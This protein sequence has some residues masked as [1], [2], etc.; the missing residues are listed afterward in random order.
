MNM[1]VIV[2]TDITVCKNTKVDVVKKND[3]KI[4]FQ[5]AYIE[6]GSREE[7]ESDI[8]YYMANISCYTDVHQID[9]DL[10]LDVQLS[11]LGISYEEFALCL[12]AY[13]NDKSLYEVYPLVEVM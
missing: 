3:V 13:L 7:L 1:N 8:G 5:N 4:A 9:L 6:C 11:E 10:D 2:N 12:V